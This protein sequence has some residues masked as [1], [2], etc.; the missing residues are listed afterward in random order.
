MTR[1]SQ[2]GWGGLITWDVSQRVCWHF[3]LPQVQDASKKD[4]PLHWSQTNPR[5]GI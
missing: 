3:N 4:G 5:D 2:K 1:K